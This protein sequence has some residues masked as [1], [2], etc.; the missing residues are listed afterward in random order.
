MEVLKE[1]SAA[2]EAVIREVRE[3]T[4]VRVGEIHYQ[5]SQPWPFPSSLMLG[6]RACAVD[7]SIRVDH[8]ELQ[9]AQWFTREQIRSR[10]LDGRLRLPPA[11]SISRRLIEGWYDEGEL[12]A[13]RDL[14]SA[15]DWA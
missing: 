5:S 6:F 7:P 4:G 8:D 15:R 13:L 9:D 3:E 10:L 2:V 1:K 12:G 14:V 11:I